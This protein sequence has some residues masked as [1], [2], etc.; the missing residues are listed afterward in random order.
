METFIH[1]GKTAEEIAEIFAIQLITYVYEPRDAPFHLALSG[2]KTPSI[3]F[4][5]L[6][7]K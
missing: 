4:S 6:A 7:E 1:T 3:L 2:G 5:L